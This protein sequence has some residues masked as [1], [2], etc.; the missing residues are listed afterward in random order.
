MSSKKVIDKKI[1]YL[2]PLTGRM[3]KE[4][5]TPVNIADLLGGTDHTL[6]DAATAIG[7]GTAMNVQGRDTAGIQFFG[8]T[9]SATVVFEGTVDTDP[10]TTHW[11]PIPGT[12]ARLGYSSAESVSF[13]A[14]PNEI[15]QF[16]VKG[17]AQIR[18]RIPAIGNGNLSAI[19]LG[20]G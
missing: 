18:M 10:N 9:T 6:Q 4:D 17:M 3:R 20:V 19:G 13:T 7:N 11:A 15:W 16:Y 1:D 12:K 8:T 2:E 14:A 5:D